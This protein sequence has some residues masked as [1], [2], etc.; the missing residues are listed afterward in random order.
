MERWF[1]KAFRESDA[2]TPW[3]EMLIATDPAGYTGICAAIAGTDFYT[4]TSGLGLPTLGL[5]GT[6]DK[7]TPPDLVRETT[8]LIRGSSFHLIRGAGHV[9]PVT[10]PGIVADHIR[11]FLASIGHV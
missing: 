11:T 9:A 1:G 6:M 2:V 7:A 8:D 3:R 5:G 4:P 10:H